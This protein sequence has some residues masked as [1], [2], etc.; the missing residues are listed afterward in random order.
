MILL[1]DVVTIGLGPRLPGRM[2]RKGTESAKDEVRAMGGGGGLYSPRCGEMFVRHA[3]RAREG[4]IAEPKQQGRKEA[5][6]SHLQV[7]SEAYQPQRTPRA[8]GRMRKLG[9]GLSAAG[10]GRWLNLHR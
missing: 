5:S 10:S 9:D 2:D 6:R 7:A 4:T 3:V 8:R 1:A